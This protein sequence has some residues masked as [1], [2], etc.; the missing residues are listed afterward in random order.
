MFE[1]NKKWRIY[2]TI[3]GGFYLAASNCT[4]RLNEEEPTNP[5]K[6]YFKEIFDTCQSLISKYTKPEIDEVFSLFLNDQDKIVKADFKIIFSYC[7]E[8]IVQNKD[9]NKTYT[10]WLN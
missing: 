9:L 1:Y 7:L 4:V 8:S 6:M 5:E 3:S 2:N 10:E